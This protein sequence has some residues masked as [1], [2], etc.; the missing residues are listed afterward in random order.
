MSSSTDTSYNL[1]KN[2]NG[3]GNGNGT[4]KNI[5][6]LKYIDID[7]KFRN[8]NMFP[9]PNDFVISITYPSRNSGGFNPVDAVSNALPYTGS[10]KAVGSNL[11]NLLTASTTTNIYLDL[12]ETSIFNYYVNSVIETVDNP[13]FFTTITS[14]DGNTK[15]AIVS[16]P[17]PIAP[18]LGVVYYIRKQQ[19]FIQTTVAA[20]PA[21]TNTTFS[22][23]GGAGITNA[24]VNNYVRFTSGLNA[25]VVSLITAYNGITK[26]ITLNTPLPNIP[27]AGDTLEIDSYS[28]DN[29]STL[30]INSNHF[31]NNTMNN[32]YE[33]ELL[34]LS[35]PNLLL[36]VDYGGYIT[37]YPYVYLEIYNEGKNLTNQLFYSNNPNTTRSV[38]KVPV[39]NY[40]GTTSFFTFVNAKTRHVLR[41]EPDQ[42]LRF[43]ITLPSGTVV[44]YSKKDNISPNAPNP[45]VQV[46]A[47]FSL[48]K[49]TTGG[50]MS[51]VGMGGRR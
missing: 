50:D 29:A 39:D 21:P 25:G 14:Y 36:N 22:I 41:I 2:V 26:V 9:N 43:R 1:Q 45:E 46:S 28:Y 38:F 40:N 11:T 47:L 8:R 32:Y 49:A 6:P 42:D 13:N 20:L 30:S 15:L 23:T 19:P 37:N 5:N 18:G 12:A 27:V 3:N 44:S 4:D 48:R 10:S 24:Y 35:M 33:L 34:H 51:L 31:M 16:P 17:F 7:S